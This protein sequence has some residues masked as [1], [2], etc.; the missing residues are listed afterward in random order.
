[1][2]VIP[3]NPKPLSGE[4]IERKE[5]R[6]QQLMDAFNHPSC[7]AFNVVLLAL[8]RYMVYPTLEATAFL[9]QSNAF[10]HHESARGIDPSLH[11]PN[12]QYILNS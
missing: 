9:H 5:Y 7:E 6:M 12:C 10:R 4:E 3:E 2:A 8:D 1:M 11:N